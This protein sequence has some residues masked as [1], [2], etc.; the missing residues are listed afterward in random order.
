ME[1]IKVEMEVEGG[2]EV[3][4]TQVE[5]QEEE[6]SS[7]HPSLSFYLEGLD[8]RQRLGVGRRDH[9]GGCAE[10]GDPSPPIFITAL[11]R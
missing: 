5:E 4:V 9:E 1:D 6:T 8:S 11:S 2:T 10:E 3:I 7:R